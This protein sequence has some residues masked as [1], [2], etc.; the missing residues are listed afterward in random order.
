MST[1]EWIVRGFCPMGCGQT[2]VISET[3]FVSCSA[4]QCPRSTAV[5]ELLADPEIEHTV[6][7]T[8]NGFTVKHP[9]RE[10]LDNA[11]L[12]CLPSV[13]LAQAGRS[14]RPPGD[15]RL[16]GYAADKHPNDWTWEPI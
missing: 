1:R 15:Y 3:G 2:L 10:R 9:L 4:E 14:P 8:R 11:L 13:K 16:T 5:T 12:K 7:L 6:T